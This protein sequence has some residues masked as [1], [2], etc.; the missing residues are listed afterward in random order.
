M[1]SEP[2]YKL[3]IVTLKPEMRVSVPKPIYWAAIHR[4]SPRFKVLDSNLKLGQLY[5]YKVIIINFRPLGLKICTY[6]EESKF[7][8]LT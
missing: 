4:V 7:D 1:K 6:I 2:R 3:R 8:S 5:Q